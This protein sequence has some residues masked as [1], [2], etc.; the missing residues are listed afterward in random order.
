MRGAP[1]DLIV[2]VGD[3]AY[4]SGTI[5]ELEERTFAVYAPLLGYVPLYG[6]AGNHEHVTDD[7]AP[8]RA[9]FA[10]PG[11]E[12]WYSFDWGQV[13]FVGLDTEEDLDE[14]AA[15]LDA[16]LAA[17]DRPW[18][19]VFMHEPPYSSGEHGSSA[20]TRAAFAP[21]LEA[22]GV[23]LALTGHDHHYERTVP[24]EGVTYVVT[25]GGGGLRELEGTSAW[26]AHAEAAYHFLQI[27]VATEQLTLHAIADDGEQL[28][29]VVI[30]RTR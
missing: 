19:I 15:W 30:P 24:I 21:I 1:Q 20:S 29:A 25:G 23:Q 11:N 17:T 27:E 16:D 14:Q 4:T 28:D 7:A 3:I 8:F 18:K 22:H 9:V 5:D 2:H 12:R 26:T 6:I 13:H 10:L